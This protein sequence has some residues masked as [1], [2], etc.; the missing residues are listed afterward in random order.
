MR[1]GDRVARIT[2][3]PAFL[4][5]RGQIWASHARSPEDSQKLL[6]REGLAPP[7]SAAVLL[8]APLSAATLLAAALLAAALLSAS[9]LVVPLLYSATMVSRAH[10]AS[11]LSGINR[12]ARRKST[13]FRIAPWVRLVGTG[14]FGVANFATHDAGVFL[15]ETSRCLVIRS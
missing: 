10:W 7:L 15:L 9:L 3:I 4:R 12:N 8:A 11:W 6:L 2:G 5:G 14:R 1:V 13:S